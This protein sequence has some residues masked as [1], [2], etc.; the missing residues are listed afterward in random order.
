M[1]CVV[2]DIPVLVLS[3]HYHN[4]LGPGSTLQ[5]TIHFVDKRGGGGFFCLYKTLC[6]LLTIFFIKLCNVINILSS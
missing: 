3:L 5:L 6:V 2:S 4:N 1:C